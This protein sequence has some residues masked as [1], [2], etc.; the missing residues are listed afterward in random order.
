MYKIVLLA[1][2]IPFT[3]L[4][5]QEK[6]KIA[7]PY[8]A[9]VGDIEFN[10]ETD[11]ENFTLCNEERIYQY[12]NN[13]GGFEYEGEKLAIEKVFASEY[14]PEVIQNE[15]GLIRIHFVVNCKGE[16]DRFRLIA[17]DDDYNEKEFA[18]SI[19]AQ[20]MRITKSLNGWKRKERN[21]QAM[22]YYQYLTFKMEDG[23][24][25]EILP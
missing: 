14:K 8:P 7:S 23:L 6:T 9:Y 4:F 13:S 11:K 25:K 21:G 3:S 2:L 24:I 19:T 10:K 15:T 1:L 17:M 5:G 16:T 20:L 12:F 18:T 22:D